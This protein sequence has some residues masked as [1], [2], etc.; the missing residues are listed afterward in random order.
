M[1]KAILLSLLITHPIFALPTWN[2]AKNSG[3]PVLYVI[4]VIVAVVLI[5]RSRS[6]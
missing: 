1:K 3:H 6:K 5:C 4:L 2:D